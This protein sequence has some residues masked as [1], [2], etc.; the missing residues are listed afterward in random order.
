MIGPI[1]QQELI[2]GGRRNRLHL[3]RWIYA[4]WLIVQVFYFYVLFVQ[5]IEANTRTNLIPA[6]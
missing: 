2:L 3:F 1:F 5:D 4:G 6:R